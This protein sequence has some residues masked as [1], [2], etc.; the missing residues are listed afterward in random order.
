MHFVCAA[1]SPI[2]IGVIDPGFVGPISSTLI[3]FGRQPCL[4]EKGAAFLRISFFRSA[5]STRAVSAQNWD[6][7]TYVDEVKKQA[8]AYS[9]PKFL[10]LDDVTAKAAETAFGS[11]KNSLVLWGVLAQREMEKRRSPLV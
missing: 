7:Q 2:N 11:F 5:P 6:R 1:C 4:I 9:G 8:L 3:N 10:N